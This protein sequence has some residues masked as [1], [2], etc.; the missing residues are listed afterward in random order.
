MLKLNLKLQFIIESS[1]YGNADASLF[2]IIICYQSW[3]KSIQDVNIWVLPVLHRCL[4]WYHDNYNYL[5]PIVLKPIYPDP[6]LKINHEVYFSAP[7]CFSTLILQ[8]FRLEEV[9][10]LT[11]RK[12]QKKFS[13]KGKKLIPKL[14][15]ILDYVNQLSNKRAQKNKT[16]HA[17]Q[18]LGLENFSVG[19]LYMFFVP[20]TNTAPTVLHIFSSWLCY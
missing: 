7:K 2:D 16:N 11:N 10:I 9:N 3:A 17:S 15:L 18:V 1:H 14:V 19:Y 12:Q 8:N 4:K 6:R 13:T 20:R 5:C